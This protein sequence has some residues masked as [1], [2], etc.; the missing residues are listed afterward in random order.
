MSGFSLHPKNIQEN[1]NLIVT[2][3]IPNI[4]KEYVYIS[5]KF[6]YSKLI[7]EK[8]YITRGL[9]FGSIEDAFHFNVKIVGYDTEF[10]VYVG[11]D[12]RIGNY[13]FMLLFITDGSYTIPKL[14]EYLQ[15]LQYDQYLLF[16]IF[17]PIFSISDIIKYYEL[18]IKENQKF[19]KDQLLLK[20][21][22]EKK[23]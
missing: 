18:L 10:H 14:M 1:L 21:K 6:L 23:R 22:E 19:V 15:Y 20:N 7:K 16:N 8:L 9:H 13:P 3:S 12:Y 5:D 2:K 11:L 4:N 17:D